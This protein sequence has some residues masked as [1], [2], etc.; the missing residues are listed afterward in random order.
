MSAEQDIREKLAAFIKAHETPVINVAPPV[1]PPTGKAEADLRDSLLEFFNSMAPNAIVSPFNMRDLLESSKF[2]YRSQNISLVFPETPTDDWLKIGDYYFVNGEPDDLPQDIDAG[3]IIAW[4]GLPDSLPEIFETIDDIFLDIRLDTTDGDGNQT[5]KGFVWSV[6]D[7]VEILVGKTLSIDFGEG[8][9]AL[10]M[11][12][13]N[14]KSAQNP[15]KPKIFKYGSG[16][17]KDLINKDGKDID[18]DLFVKSCEITKGYIV[19]VFSVE[20]L[21]NRCYR[22][23]SKKTQI[24]DFQS[25]NQGSHLVNLIALTE[26]EWEFFGEDFL[27]HAAIAIHNIIGAYGRNIGVRSM[28]FN[29]GTVAN[30]GT[31]I[32]ALK[33]P[34]KGFF[35]N[36]V[37]Q[38]YENI[39]SALYYSVLQ[40]W[41]QWCNDAGEVQANAI[42]CETM[43]QGILSFRNI[44]CPRA[45]RPY[46][47]Y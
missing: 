31:I 24:V 2:A 45:T 15:H 20:D 30:K 47:R 27:E 36:Y 9:E 12:K 33:V 6:N 13:V 17:D 42:K 28:I 26:D 14:L 18:S 46:R 32:Y 43:R 35:H 7:E 23:T 37:I 10:E 3:F 44:G 21:F 41:A 40:Q 29:L 19:L 16:E 4:D 5:W 39:R 11:V 1:N 25:Q 38:L 34:E 8:L 22:Y